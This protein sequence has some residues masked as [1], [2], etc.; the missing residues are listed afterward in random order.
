ML[1]QQQTQLV[2]GLQE[3]YHRLLA[4][5]Q[6]HGDALSESS[7]HPLTHDILAA[8]DLLEMRRDGS[9]DSE[10]FEDDVRILQQRLFDAGAPRMRRKASVSSDSER[11]HQ[12]YSSDYSHIRYGHS[13]GLTTP[14]LVKSSTTINSSGLSPAPSPTTLYPPSASKRWSQ[15][16]GKQSPPTSHGSN[17]AEPFQDA[18]STAAVMG[19]PQKM[20]A[21]GQ[22]HSPYA[23]EAPHI[24]S[25]L[26]DVVDMTSFDDWRYG[27]RHDSTTNTMYPPQ[28]ANPWDT[29]SPMQDLGVGPEMDFD[30][31]RWLVA[32]S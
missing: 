17:D 6:W 9:G 24:Q 31:T 3:L 5:G 2:A 22:L 25:N 1:E 32:Q 14:N 13:T 7:G 11:S 29:I 4:S 20:N 28:F 12:D 8:L 16:P 21:A 15:P 10:K 27:L 23:T 26:D 19:S 18:W 30:F